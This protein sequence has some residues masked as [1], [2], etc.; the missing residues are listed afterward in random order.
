MCFGFPKKRYIVDA[1]QR[2][3]RGG[4]IAGVCGPSGGY[5]LVCKGTRL[6]GLL[7]GISSRA[8]IAATLEIST[9]RE[10]VDMTI[11]AILPFCAEGYLST[12]LFD[13]LY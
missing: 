5:R 2:W 9:R 13:G 7:V 4:F 10:I 11:V 1:L 12:I 6:E 8:V 3:V